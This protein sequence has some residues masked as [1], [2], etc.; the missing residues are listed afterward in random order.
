MIERPFVFPGILNPGVTKRSMGSIKKGKPA[1][2]PVCRFISKVRLTRFKRRHFMKKHFW[3]KLGLITIILF[4]LSCV[5]VNIYFPAK[6]VE[7]AADQ[8]VKE[9]R[10]PEATQPAQPGTKP[11]QGFLR[12]S[13]KLAFFANEAWAETATTV[14]NAKIRAIK[15]SLKQRDPQLRP[16]FDAGNI[17]EGK[18]GRVIIRNMSG[19]DLKKQNILKSLVSSTNSDRE[20]LYAEVAKALKVD[21]S[22]LNRVAQEFAQQ[23]QQYSGSGWYIQQPNGTWKKK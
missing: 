23:W 2:Q 7:Q 20:Q 15:N 8:I 16:Y 3:S 22:Q 1:A 12:R 10:P 4:V 6:E 14:N 19:L 9:I 21:P 11:D 18:S 13:I 5:T 17:G